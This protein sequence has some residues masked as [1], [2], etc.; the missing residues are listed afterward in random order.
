[1]GSSL[2]YCK[3]GSAVYFTGGQAH[4]HLRL[5]TRSLIEC[6]RRYPS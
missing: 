4:F 6:V 1:M 3:R 5:G 2:A